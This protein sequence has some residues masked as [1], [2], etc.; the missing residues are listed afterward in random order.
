M[1][2]PE[3]AEP[4][5]NTNTRAKLEEYLNEMIES[6]ERRT[7]IALMIAETFTQERAIMVAKLLHG[8]TI[9]ALVV[10]G[11]G[12]GFGIWYFVG[13]VVAAGI[14]AWE[15]HLVRPGDLARLDSAFFTM[16]GVMS[17]VVFGFAVLD[18]IA[19]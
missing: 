13:V 11:S 2:A 1:S 10:F 17:L 4:L 3:G 5:P 12:A 6:P 16:N 19:A 15:H 8:I 7:E 18:R 14:L 9:P